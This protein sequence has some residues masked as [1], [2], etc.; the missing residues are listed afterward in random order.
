[1]GIIKYSVVRGRN[2]SNLLPDNLAEVNLSKKYMCVYAY[3]RVYTQRESKYSKMVT[4]DN[5]RGK[6]IQWTTTISNF[7]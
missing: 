5:C 6:R 3:E 4:I 1:M 2:V 7:L